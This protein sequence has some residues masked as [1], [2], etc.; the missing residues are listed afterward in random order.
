MSYFL[1]H[2]DYIVVHNRPMLEGIFGNKT[3][4][5]VL[6]YI[7]HHGE[8]HT[9]AIAED[10]LISKTAVKQQL[11]RFEQAGVLVSKEMGRTRIYFFNRKSALTRPVL[12]LVSIVYDTLSITE[13]EKI[14]R[15]RRRPRRKG[16]PI[17]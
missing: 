6:L 13:K 15:K 9:A 16:K 14:F 3:A 2:M 5:K 10:L 8:S 7:H 17:L 1:V 4:E 12:D 11:Q